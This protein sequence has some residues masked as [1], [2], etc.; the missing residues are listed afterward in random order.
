[1]V[2]SPPLPVS[3][4][5]LGV[6]REEVGNGVRRLR[7]PAVLAAV[8]SLSSLFSRERDGRDSTGFGPSIVERKMVFSVKMAMLI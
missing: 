6:C 1:M 8:L 7:L 2:P 3:P 4:E 5:G